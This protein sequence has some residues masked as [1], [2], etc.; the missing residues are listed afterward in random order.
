VIATH[1]LQTDT[2]TRLRLLAPSRVV[3]AAE[4]LHQAEHKLVALSF[5]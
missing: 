4:V 5:M 1:D 2:L 3:T